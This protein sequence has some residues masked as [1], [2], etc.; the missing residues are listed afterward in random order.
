MTT[1]I[2]LVSI[3]LFLLVACDKKE[4]DITP[5]RDYTGTL[6]LDY[7]RSFPT[8]T[9][10]M[11][12]PVEISASGEAVVTQP[13]PHNFQGE[14]DKMI[15]G[16]RIKIR[17]EGIIT[18]SDV[19]PVWKVENGREYLEVSLSFLLEGHQTIW[20][21][22]NYYWN[23]TSASPYSHQHPVKCPMMFRIDNALLSE[24]VCAARCE[25]CWGY[26]NFRWRLQLNE[27]P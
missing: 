8:F 23:Q 22:D 11:S 4:D 10:T 1:R 24:S 25:D 19:D 17:E 16:E 6:T 9:S 2:V 3:L 18:I 14:S 26:N 7:S 21:W 20:E 15:R 13:L 27:V 12:I 5:G